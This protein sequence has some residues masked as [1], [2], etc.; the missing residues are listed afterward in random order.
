MYLFQ[1]VAVE[2]GATA[3]V[4]IL[5]ANIAPLPVTAGKCYMIHNVDRLEQTFIKATFRTEVLRL[6]PFVRCYVAY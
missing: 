3:H 6:V 5:S 4:G 1:I 2:K